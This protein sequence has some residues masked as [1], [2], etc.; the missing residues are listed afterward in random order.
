M[1]KQK[2]TSAPF[3]LNKPDEAET[4]R[5]KA[6]LEVLGNRVEVLEWLDNYACFFPG[7]QKT[8]NEALLARMDKKQALN[9]FCDEEKEMLTDM[10]FFFS[11]MAFFSELIST[12]HQEL[13]GEKELTEQMLNG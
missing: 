10:N 3:V 5:M 12:W 11:K 4:E 9:I 8:V 13:S 7:W 6:L 1:E 2:E